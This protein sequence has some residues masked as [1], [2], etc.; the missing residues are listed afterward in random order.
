MTQITLIAAC[1]ANRCIGKDNSIPWYIPEDFAFFKAFTLG[2]PIIMGRKTWE[3]LPR[4]P[5]PGRRNIIITRQAGYSA[6]GAET[7]PDLETA[8]SMCQ[9]QDETVII[10]GAQIYAQALPFA[11][12]IRLTEIDLDVEGD[13]HFPEFSRTDWQENSRSSHT[14]TDG[15]RYDFVHYRRP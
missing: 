3:S 10:G 9:N 12:D 7:A 11:T 14:G 2:K 13:A 15:I 4:K 5:L 6:E 8:L 1:A